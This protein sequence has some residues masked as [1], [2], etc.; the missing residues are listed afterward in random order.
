VVEEGGSSLQVWGVV[1]IGEHGS[2][3]AGGSAAMAG[4]ERR[5]R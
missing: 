3:S 2:L 1:E 5:S 4:R